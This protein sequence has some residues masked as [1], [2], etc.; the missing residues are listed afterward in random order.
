MRYQRKHR[1]NQRDL[2]YGDGSGGSVVLS[3]GA[4]P[5]Y[6]SQSSN[7]ASNKNGR[8]VINSATKTNGDEGDFSMQ[9]NPSSSSSSKSNSSKSSNSS[10]SSNGNAGIHSPSTQSSNDKSLGAGP[11]VGIVVGI[12]A[13]FFFLCLFIG[14]YRRKMKKR[15]RVIKLNDNTSNVQMKKAYI[16]SSTLL[17]NNSNQFNVMT[18]KSQHSKS[19]SDQTNLIRKNSQASSLAQSDGTSLSAPWFRSSGATTT[20][21]TNS[22]LAMMSRSDSDRS[23]FKYR[24]NQTRNSFASPLDMMLVVFYINPFKLN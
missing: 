19:A 7:I 8:T 4:A 14:K 9:E 13:F 22:D 5:N 12:I 6:E 11:I 18:V 20:E 3:S 21:E 17:Q 15:S 16:P 1:L 10:S 23:R 24:N 2:W